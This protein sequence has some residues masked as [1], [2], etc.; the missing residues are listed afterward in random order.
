M[1]QQQ[2]LINLAYSTVLLWGSSAARASVCDV[3]ACQNGSVCVEEKANFSGHNFKEEQT[4][5]EH[6]RGTDPYHC[7]CD[8]NWTGVLCEIPFDE[9]TDTDNNHTC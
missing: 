2:L 1:K 6:G 8:A 3:I 4:V 9:C 7:Q 5:Q